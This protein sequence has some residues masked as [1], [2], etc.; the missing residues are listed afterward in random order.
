M[1]VF[2]AAFVAGNTTQHNRQ[3]RK[4]IMDKIFAEMFSKH[5]DEIIDGAYL[6]YLPYYEEQSAEAREIMGISFEEQNKRIKNSVKHFFHDDFQNHTL[7]GEVNGYYDDSWVED[8]KGKNKDPKATEII[9][10][11]ILGNKPFMDIA[12]G[13]GMGL[14]P[15]II[16]MN[17][18]IPCL[19]TDINA[20]TI[21]Y[22]RLFTNKNFTEYNINFASFDNL[23]IPIKDESIE[24]ITSYQGI[25]SSFERPA[26]GQKINIY[27]FSTDREKPINEVYRILKPGGRFITVEMNRECDFDLQKIYNNYNEHGK[28]FGIYTYDEIQAVLELLIEEPWCDKFTSAGF[29]IE[30]EKKHLRKYSLNNVMSFLH[31]FTGYHEIHHWEEGS[32]EEK[33]RAGILKYNIDDYDPNIG[34]DFY[35]VDTFYVLRKPW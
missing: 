22:Q 5:P 35:H 12:S 28:L 14:A 25:T 10:Q 24:Y 17:P 26:D 16:G 8:V 29:Q 2:P 11:I 9:S 7:Q 4:I 6:Y 20:P 27:Q 31:S 15:Y 33:R 30:V 34:M 1:M 13:V 19:I 18:K 32:W 21:K 23:N 3:W